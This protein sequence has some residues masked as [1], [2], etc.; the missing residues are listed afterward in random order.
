LVHD[1][2]DLKAILDA[3][4]SSTVSTRDSASV[5][6]GASGLHR[7]RSPG[8]EPPSSADATAAVGAETARSDEEGSGIGVVDAIAPALSNQTLIRN[9][10][11]VTPIV[12]DTSVKTGAVGQSEDQTDFASKRP[13]SSPSPINQSL[14]KSSFSPNV[15][16]SEA[17]VGE[18]LLAAALTVHQE[19]LIIKTQSPDASPIL[20]AS[21]TT[22][23]PVIS[24]TFPDYFLVDD[25]AS[26]SS[27]DDHVDDSDIE[28]KKEQGAVDS[29]MIVWSQRDDPE[30]RLFNHSR[31]G[32]HDT[33]WEES[34]FYIEQCLSQAAALDAKETANAER[35]QTTQTP[36]LSHDQGLS[37]RP[38]LCSD[39][40]NSTSSAQSV[41]IHEEPD[42][43]FEPGE[44]TLSPEIE[45][46]AASHFAPAQSP[47]DQPLPSACSEYHQNGLAVPPLIHSMSHDNEGPSRLNH[48]DTKGPSVGTLE[49]FTPEYT[50]DPWAAEVRA[51]LFL[52][53]LSCS[54]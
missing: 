16:A 35:D 30:G 11:E 12:D 23:G 13:K 48:L 46:V 18:P 1:L 50:L 39:Q 40:G 34:E 7:T 28:L 38:N 53:H 44:F 9:E 54:H 27:S 8:P 36:H 17:L 47:S 3:H 10:M 4:Y 43:R 15:P 33:E 26:Y 37:A 41:D 52:P 42:A 51:S 45:F 22:G 29:E 25:N 20:F 2:I 14:N 21:P 32:V 31:T 6:M 24:S 49:S 19:G 5:A